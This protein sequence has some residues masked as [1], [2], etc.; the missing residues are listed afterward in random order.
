ML[1][2][3][4]ILCLTERIKKLDLQSRLVNVSQTNESLWFCMCSIYIMNVFMYISDRS[5]N[6]AP[7]ITGP[8]PRGNENHNYFY[9]R[10]QY[11]LLLCRTGGM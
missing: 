10:S 3:A 6:T 5:P 4:T 11:N 9:Y 7:F 1:C 2:L 8:H